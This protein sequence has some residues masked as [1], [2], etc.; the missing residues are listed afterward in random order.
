MA[1]RICSNVAAMVAV[2]SA[3]GAFAQDKSPDLTKAGKAILREKIAVERRQ[4]NVHPLSARMVTFPL[5]MCT[6]PG[7]L[8][9]A[10]H[11][12]GAIA[13]PPRYDWVGTFSDNRAAVRV[14]G[15]YGFVDEE[16]REVVKPQYRIVDDY[17]FGFAQVD[18]DGKSGLIDRD[19]EMVIEPRY[20]FIQA[21]ARDRFVV[22]ERRQLGG[23]AGGEDFSGTKVALTAS[24]GVSVIG[25]FLGSDYTEPTIATDVI[26]ISGQQIGPPRRP[27][28]GLV[29]I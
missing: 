15:L 16:G 20:G 21:I 4:L 14:G 11:R 6:F 13:V 12:D 7:G 28:S 10:V 1:A 2:M 5:A 3:H 8:C 29:W 25:V 27:S 18:V 24:R 9:G 23:M 22:S 26:D 17:K 19:G